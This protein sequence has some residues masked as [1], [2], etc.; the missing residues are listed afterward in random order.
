MNKRLASVVAF[1]CLWGVIFACGSLAVRVQASMLLVLLSMVAFPLAYTVATYL[2]NRLAS[3]PLEPKR[4]PSFIFF[5]NF[6]V[7]DVLHL[8]NPFT[9]RFVLTQLLASVFLRPRFQDSE[10]VS[11]QLPFRGTWLVGAGGTTRRNSHSWTILAQRYAYDFVIGPSFSDTANNHGEHLADYSAYGQPIFAPIDGKVVSVRRNARDAPA[12]GSGW[13]DWWSIDPRG[14]HVLLECQPNTF[15]LLAHLR[16]HSVTVDRG[17][18][19]IK[20]AKLGECGNSGRSTEPHLHL[21][22]QRGSGLAFA[23]GLP[24]VFSSCS[25]EPASEDSTNNAFALQRG[26]QVKCDTISR[27]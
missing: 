15:I 23:E 2:Y 18:S 24:I 6:F 20:G 17:E 13:L 21:H 14:N 8:F 9:L 26:M 12:P 19:V 1:T 4:S 5:L 25:I 10:P 7:S 3:S 16:P 27:H 22:C 11:L